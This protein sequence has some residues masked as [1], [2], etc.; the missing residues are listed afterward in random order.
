MYG[1]SCCNVEI[2][3]DECCELLK[4]LHLDR[5]RVHPALKMKTVT[6]SMF[7]VGKPLLS[8]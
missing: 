1:L 8:A 3:Y 6:K 2:N 5:L 4:S 7:S